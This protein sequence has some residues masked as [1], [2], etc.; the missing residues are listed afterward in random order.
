MDMRTTKCMTADSE[1][2]THPLENK[3][4]EV[5]EVIYPIISKALEEGITKSPSPELVE[6]ADRIL[7][8]QQVQEKMRMLSVTEKNR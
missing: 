8:I 7:D 3:P 1:Q 4:S 5:I 6:K 2:M